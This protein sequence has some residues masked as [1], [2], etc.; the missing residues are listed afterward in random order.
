MVLATPFV[1]FS[2]ATADA[3]STL[4]TESRVAPFRAKMEKWVEARELLSKEESEWLVDRAYLTSTKKLLQRERDAL[5]K[6]VQDLEASYTGADEERRDLLLER[7]EYQRMTRSLED[8]LRVLEGQVQNV[9]P[10]LPAPL[11]DRLEPLIVQIP[12]DPEHTNTPVGQRLMNILGLLAQTE[13]FNST[14]TLVGET[15]AIGGEQSAGQD[16]AQKVQVRTLYWGLGE[17]IY[18]DTQGRVAGI[19]RPTDTGWVFTEDPSLRSDAKLLLDIYEGN[20]DT[21]DFVPIPVEIQ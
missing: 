17:A 2:V 14:A 8:E 12:D 4:S 9:I 16:A 11:Q 1:M 20:V 19:G 10:R 7:G 6:E 18:V 3:A 13:K 21:I 5:R 15:R